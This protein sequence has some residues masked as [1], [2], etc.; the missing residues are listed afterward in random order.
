LSNEHW[1][2]S[3]SVAPREVAISVAG[4]LLNDLIAEGWVKIPELNARGR[5][6]P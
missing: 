5:D 4:A 1:F 6:V 3:E 2:A